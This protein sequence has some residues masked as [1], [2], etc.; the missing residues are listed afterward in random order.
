[1]QQKRGLYIPARPLDFL[2]RVPDFP[3]IVIVA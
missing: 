3:E 1:M 2:R